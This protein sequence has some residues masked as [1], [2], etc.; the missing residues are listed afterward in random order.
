M[1][2]P[3]IEAFADEIDDK[4][5]GRFER[6][7]RCA[8]SMPGATI[9]ARNAKFDLLLRFPIGPNSR[10]EGEKPLVIARIKFTE[11]RVGH[12][13]WFLRELVSMAPKYGYESIAIE[14]A[15]PN[16]GIQNFVRKFE[17]VPVLGVSSDWIVSVN[18]LARRF[19]A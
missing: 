17:F 13:T 10:F 3:H 7:R 19:S 12:G 4:L 5:K 18:Q 15:N 2:L 8:Y 9:D 11:Q 14:A 1:N 6:K 16:V